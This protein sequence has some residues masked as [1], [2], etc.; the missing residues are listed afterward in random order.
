MASTTRQLAS[1]RASQKKIWMCL[2]IAK[3][4]GCQAKTYFLENIRMKISS[5]ARRKIDGN[6]VILLPPRIA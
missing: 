2:C 5:R 6:D 1:W 4:V 3:A